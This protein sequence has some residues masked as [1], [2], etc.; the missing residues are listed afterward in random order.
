MAHLDL[1]A[2]ELLDHLEGVLSN[3]PVEIVG[4]S[5]AVEIK[6]QGVSKGQAVEKMLAQMFGRGTT[7]SGRRGAGGS[8]GAGSSSMDAGSSH[9]QQAS[10]SPAQ[11][12]D[13]VLCIGDDRSD[14]D[15]FTSM[16]IMRSSPQL[17]TSEVSWLA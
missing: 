4:G 14:E 15:M 17:M 16:E 9:G 6:P 7:A 1:Q 10:S 11:S 8:G 2:K 3:K 12:P 5:A 13:F